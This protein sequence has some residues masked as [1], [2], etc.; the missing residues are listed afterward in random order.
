MPPTYKKL[1]DERIFDMP[2][3]RIGFEI[4]C[5]PVASSYFFSEEG[6][7]PGIQDPR[8]CSVV[9]TKSNKEYVWTGTRSQMRNE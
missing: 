8:I 3:F 9:L 5:L 1:S 4:R 2:Q 6:R 7:K